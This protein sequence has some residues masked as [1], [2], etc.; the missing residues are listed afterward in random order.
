MNYVVRDVAANLEVISLD[1]R[2]DAT[3]HIVARGPKPTFAP[4][5]AN[6]SFGFDLG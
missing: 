2:E 1:I 6:G 5:A 3:I 4:Y